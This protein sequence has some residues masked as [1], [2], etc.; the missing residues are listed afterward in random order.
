MINQI[1]E[2]LIKRIDPVFIIVFGS[3]AK[4]K[5]HPKSDIDIAFYDLAENTRDF[6]HEMN[7]LRIG[8][9]SMSC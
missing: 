6:N 5:T 2:F 9:D 7:W 1:R 8:H 3:F 4:D